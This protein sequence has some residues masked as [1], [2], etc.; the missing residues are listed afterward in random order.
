MAK[1]GNKWRKWRR[2]WRQQWQCHAASAA[3]GQ[4]LGGIE[5][6]GIGEMTQKYGENIEISENEIA[7]RNGSAR[8]RKAWQAKAALQLKAISEMA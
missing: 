3:S 7:R 6:R 4:L 5:K 2:K 8:Q 1:T